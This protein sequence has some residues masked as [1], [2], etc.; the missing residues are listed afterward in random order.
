MD[1]AAGHGGHDAHL[2]DV[3]GRRASGE[4]VALSAEVVSRLRRPVATW[5]SMNE[6]KYDLKGGGTACTRF[7]SVRP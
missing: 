4:G 3:E 1:W 7:T 2:A 6:T 5:V